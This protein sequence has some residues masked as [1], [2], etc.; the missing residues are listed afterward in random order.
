MRPSSARSLA[1]LTGLA[2]AGRVGAN[3]AAQIG[4]MKVQEEI[5]AI[6]TPFGSGPA[7]RVTSAEP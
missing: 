5:D 2:L 3:I 1:L 6:S 4:T 7:V